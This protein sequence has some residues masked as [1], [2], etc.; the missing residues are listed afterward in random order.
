[1]TALR[2]DPLS[3]LNLMLIE[4]VP[5]GRYFLRHRRYDRGYK[6][7]LLAL[8][9]WAYV[10]VAKALFVTATKSWMGQCHSCYGWPALPAVFLSS[11]HCSVSFQP[12]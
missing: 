7:V 12:H 9:S 4:S 6:T 3:Y 1:M 5:G 10:L 11:G 2:L 8:L